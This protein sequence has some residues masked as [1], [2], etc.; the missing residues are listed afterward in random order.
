MTAIAAAPDDAASLDGARSRAQA[1][2]AMPLPPSRSMALR[3]SLVR[4]VVTG[5]HRAR[6]LHAMTTA[7]V[8]KL[9]PGAATFALVATS[10]GK[11]VGQLRLEVDEASISLVTER[12]SLAPILETLKKHKVAD[13]VRFGEPVP[14]EATLAVYAAPGEALADLR[15]A[16]LADLGDLAA[17][18]R[19]TAW[20]AD[21]SEV[22]RPA[23]HLRGA[24]AA[25]ERARAMLA[26]AGV[27][28]LDAAAWEAARVAAGWPKDGVDLGPDDLSL[29][30][31]R[32]LATVSWTKGCF[33]GQEVFVMA[34]DR[35]EVP[36][37]LRGVVPLPGQ[38][39]GSGE[40]IL[41]DDGKVVGLVGSTTP[42]LG[43]AIIKRKHAQSGS[44][45][46]RE[47][48]RPV[49][50]VALPAETAT[51]GEA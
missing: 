32:L 6:F 18:L 43:L 36:K 35:G 1:S 49:T 39:L 30:A 47:D 31:E 12:G 2:P 38:A 4:V 9:A 50:V 45:L 41:S 27:A 21:R 37:V 23:L 24:V 7:E 15:A 26:A 25:V 19:M 11:H 10:T 16:T 48:G 8:M 13:D 33:L 29:Y 14:D 51:P 3:D 20:E 34:R 40:K 44:A 28:S 46:R 5:R 17:A 42:E 22:G